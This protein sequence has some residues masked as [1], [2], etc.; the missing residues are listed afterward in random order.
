LA[1]EGG[2]GVANSG[3]PAAMPAGQAVGRDQVLT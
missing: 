3:E 2:A 1:G